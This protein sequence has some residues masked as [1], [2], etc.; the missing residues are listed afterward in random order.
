MKTIQV[1]I[2]SV[3]VTFEGCYAL[4]VKVICQMAAEN[5]KGRKK[6]PGLLQNEH[7]IIFLGTF[8]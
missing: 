1:F 5:T 2:F 8:E 6:L 7:E 3:P 4:Y